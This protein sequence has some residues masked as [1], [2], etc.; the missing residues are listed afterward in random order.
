MRGRPR[1]GTGLLAGLLALPETAAL[2]RLSP[3]GR[4]LFLTRVV[5]LFAYGLLSV[6]LALYLA[7]AGLS[8]RQIGLVLSL[9]L[10]GD[11]AISI[12]ITTRADR[13]GRRR[14]L[15]LGAGLMVLAGLVFAST[16]DPLVLTAA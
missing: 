13:T 6:V 5:R 11:A 2:R 3:D 14:M 8:D 16:G 9:T 1:P 10:A 12:W 7:A 15:Q 4:R